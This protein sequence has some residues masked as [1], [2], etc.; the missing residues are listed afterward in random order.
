MTSM[1]ITIAA[2]MTGS[3]LAIPTAVMTESSEKTM[4]SRRIW[5]SVQ[6]K[7]ARLPAPGAAGWSTSSLS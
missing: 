1:A 4:S 3:W 2:I 6:A 5:T 7:P